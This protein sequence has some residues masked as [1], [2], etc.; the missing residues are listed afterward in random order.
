[1]R[2]KSKN[3]MKTLK[4]FENVPYNW[5]GESLK[6]SDCSG[7]ICYA[8]NKTFNTNIR[9]TANELF[10]KYFTRIT[11]NNPENDICALFFLKNNKAIHVSGYIGNDLYLNESSLEPKYCGVIRNEKELYKMYKHLVIVKRFLNWSIL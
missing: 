4:L 3:F 2:I 8:L 7:T 9:I 1:M 5:G 10:L 6:G 11:S